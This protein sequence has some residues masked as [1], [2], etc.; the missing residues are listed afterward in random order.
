MDLESGGYGAVCGR[1]LVE[2]HDVVNTSVAA[3]GRSVDIVLASVEVGRAFDPRAD[4]HDVSH[5]LTYH[6]D[7][8]DVVQR[9]EPEVRPGAAYLP[10]YAVKAFQP[11][12]DDGLRWRA[13]GV[14]HA[15]RGGKALHPERSITLDS[16]DVF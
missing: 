16:R 2:P 1:G 14:Q 5:V 15:Q 8:D 12:A 10:A 13:A 9:A 7:A 4:S 6:P 11:H 3:V